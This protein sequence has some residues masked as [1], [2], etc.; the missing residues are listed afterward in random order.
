MVDLKS[1][2]DI[3]QVFCDID[4]F[5]LGFESTWKQAHL[6]QMNGEKLSRCRMCMSEIMTI[7]I[8]FHSSGYR[9]FKEFY[10]LQVIPQWKNAFPNLVSYN[11][12]V[13]VMP[14]SLMA[15]CCYLHTRRGHVTGISF[16]DSTPITVCHKCRATTLKVYLLCLLRFFSFVKLTLRRSPIVELNL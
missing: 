11:R 10:T 15:L 3:T 5:C 12:F 2:M 8:G 6:P 7:V 14:W 4:D 9:T 13:E 1:R 16:I